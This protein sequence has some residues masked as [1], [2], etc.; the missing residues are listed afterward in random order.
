[1]N[2]VLASHEITYHARQHQ[3]LVM[4]A[5]IALGVIFVSIGII[6]WGRTA[7]RKK[8][9]VFLTLGVAIALLVS[10]PLVVA[11][12]RDVRPP[13]AV[14]APPPAPWNPCTLPADALTRSGVDPSTSERG[15][16]GV[17]LPDSLTCGWKGK[18][19]AIMITA[20]ST[21][22]ISD[23]RNR[24]GTTV[25]AEAPIAGHRSFTLKDGVSSYDNSCFLAIPFLAGGT[26]F[27]QISRS[28]LSRDTTPTC[29]T[30][31]RVG[32]VLV[33][34]MPK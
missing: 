23:V 32:N 27:M 17:E 34:L 22:K 14:P 30:A 21:Y 18:D 26:T 13:V 24:E 12:R 10:Y 11:V 1:M 2:S 4:S 3:I 19:Y 31:V 16:S 5:L 20:S 8:G 33:P 28:S 25:I 15:I 7:P 9:K 6:R 29:D